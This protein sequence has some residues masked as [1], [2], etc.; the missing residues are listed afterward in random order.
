MTFRPLNIAA[1]ALLTLTAGLAVA[2]EKPA[3]P[4][5]TAPAEK[6]AGLESFSQRASYT[7]GR[8]SM[9]QM[10]M[11]FEQAKTQGIP[12]DME[13]MLR[14]VKEFL[15]DKPS[16]IS[17]EDAE[18]A[19]IEMQKVA[20]EAMKKAQAKAMEEAKEKSEK[21]AK[22]AAERD[23]PFL[24]KN[25]AEKGVIT[26]AT[27]LQIL[28]IKEGTGAS[29]KAS[30]KVSVHYR[31]TLIDGTEFDSSFKRNEPAIFQVNRVIPGWTEALQLMKEGGKAKLVIPTNLAY[32]EDSQDPIPPFSTLIFE[33][34]LLKVN[35]PAPEPKPTK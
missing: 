27:G 31:G 28:H 11:Q 20:T 12:V 19:M 15:A 35:P 30:D 3:A 8:R 32:G 22:I 24:D 26:T 6:I 29:P 13:A 2:E 34:E 14:G 10:K 21:G 23:K 18:N 16:P 9:E 25:K 33:V 1:F 17:P 5:T 4:P 7:I